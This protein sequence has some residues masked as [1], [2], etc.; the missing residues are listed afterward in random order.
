ML[1]VVVCKN[2]HVE[3]SHINLGELDMVP[4]LYKTGQNLLKDRITLNCTFLFSY[5]DKLNDR[6]CEFLNKS[7]TKPVTSFHW[8][9]LPASCVSTL[10]CL[11]SYVSS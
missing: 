4:I 7:H 9:V 2:I 6:C 10:S 1:W 8:V 5:N 11:N 3:T